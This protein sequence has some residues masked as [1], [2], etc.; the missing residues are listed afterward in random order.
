MSKPDSASSRLCS[1]RAVIAASSSS[2]TAAF[3]AEPFEERMN[4]VGVNDVHTVHTGQ[5]EVGD[6]HATRTG[7]RPAID[8]RHRQPA[9]V[10]QRRRVVVDDLGKRDIEFAPFRWRTADSG[11]RSTTSDSRN[12]TTSSAF[13]A[14]ACSTNSAFTKPGI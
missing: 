10:F 13:N 8:E 12:W 5:I 7:N 6:E 14:T 2:R 9:E 1:T 3:G 11:K 4:G